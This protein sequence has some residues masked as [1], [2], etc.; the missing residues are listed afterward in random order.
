MRMKAV[1]KL[2]PEPGLELIETEVPAPRP[3][4]VLV[5]VK[6]TA[7]CGTDV[8]IYKW[9]PWS[10]K[11]LRPPLVIGHEFAGEIVTCGEQVRDLRPGLSVSAEGHI[12]SREFRD[13]H[14]AQQH[15]DPAA[16]CIGISRAG[17]FAEYLTVPATNVWVNPPEVPHEIAALQDPFGNAVH[18]ASAF[19][20]A[21]KQVLVTGCGP[22]GLMVVMLARVYGAA[23]VLATDV[24]PQRLSMAGQLGAD[25]VFDA[26]DES[27]VDAVIDQTGGGADVLLELSGAGAGIRQGLSALRAGGE[28]A[29]LGLTGR[30]LELDWDDLVVLKGVTLK[31]IYG[32]RMW[33]TWHRMRGLLRSGAIDLRPLITHE[34]PLEEFETAFAKLIHPGD[35]PVA[36]IVLRP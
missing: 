4:E 12:V 1:A 3:D 25:Q 17:C 29:V 16:S 24:S 36:K 11:H 14:P 28:C 21:G 26:R 34:L 7:I 31:G 32:R 18:T 27:L 30:P 19:E 15:L 20:L 9:D 2:R 10:A 8:H 5:K 13:Q 22:I 33:D 6:A 23:S 35:E